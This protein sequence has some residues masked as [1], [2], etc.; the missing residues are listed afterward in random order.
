M[1][2][3]TEGIRHGSTLFD[4]L[5]LLVLALAGYLLGQSGIPVEDGGEAIT[6]ARLGGTMHPPGMPL[7][8]LLLRVSWLAGEA[9]PA[10]LM[11]LCSAF[12]LWLLFRKAGA[13]GLAMALAVLSMPAFRE[14]VL[15][16]DAY[17]P[18]FLLFS[19]ALA[20]RAA[21]A[22]LAFYLTGLALSVHPW[23]LVLPAASGIRR[24]NAPAAAAFMLA[25]VSLY[26]ALPLLSAAECAVDWGSP[27]MF[28][29]F[30]M[31]ISAAGYRE[32]YGASMGRFATDAL[33]RHLSSLWGM[34]RPAFLLPV[35]L[36]AI[37]MWRNSPLSLIRPALLILLD[38][39]FVLLVNPMAS[40][41]SQTGWLSLLAFCALAAA[42]CEALPRAASLALAAAVALASMIA[43]GDPLP[44]QGTEVGAFVSSA[45]LDAGLFISDNDLL[46][47]CWVEKYGRDLR[48]D[49]V[50]LSTGNFS[51]WFERLARRYNPD[52][53]TSGGL[54]DVGG[55]GTPREVV[56]ARLVEMTIRNNPH[57]RF[58]FDL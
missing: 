33:L 34:L 58:F 23:G 13:A 53:D 9:G 1:A 17:G 49:A 25:G 41:T 43:P 5:F 10:I 7:L 32:V 16:W 22:Q 31:Q 3:Q 6:V 11:S 38:L 40:G 52:L 2:S 50:L 51:P 18:L 19:I 12:S 36:G 28:T 56:V 30:M 24:Q 37:A 14:R 54:N 46:Y 20:A 55:P 21:K 35:A 26:L 57:R 15:A 29:R 48:P 45:P 42:A 39:F 44:D 27:S 4:T 47:G 8:A